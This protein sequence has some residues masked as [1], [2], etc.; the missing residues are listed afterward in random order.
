MP[1][2]ADNG[3]GAEPAHERLE[4]TSSKAVARMRL[5]LGWQSANARHTDCLIAPRLSLRRDLFPPE[6]EAQV[7]GQTVGH[8]ASHRFSPGELLAAPDDRLC[9]ELP[10]TRFDRYFLGRGLIEPRAGRFYP[11]GILAG[12]DGVSRLDRHPFRVAGV[13]DGKL[14]VDLNHPLADRELELTVTVEDIWALPGEHGG[15]CNDIAV[16]V[17]GNGPGM[18]ARWRGQPTD[19]WSDLPY[20]R[21]DAG[22]DS[23]FYAR[24][25][26]VDHLDTTALAQVRGLYGRLLPQG[27]RVLDL[28]TSWH[29]HLPDPIGAGQ[30][31]GLGM[32]RE[33]LEANPVLD[34]RL[35]HDLNRSPDLP[36]PDAAFDAVVCTVSVEYL[37][38]P[39][40]VF[41]E[42]ARALRPGGRF[43]VTFSNRWFPPKVIR[44]WEGIHELERP[45]LVSEYF[46]ESGLFENLQTWSMRGLPRP[47]EDKYA[48]R[49]PF[50]DPVYAVWAERVGS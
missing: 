4:R 22:P 44:V 23:A 48:D 38:R 50:S 9:F 21:T 3:L 31:T 8:R 17:C 11:K 10:A 33:E 35:V 43:V 45:G 27:G 13:G 6:L 32:N 20:L 29:S 15:R 7:M 19:F 46:L 5:E 30:V 37:T 24:P 41:R 26:F 28:M 39:L 47:E 42:V 14:L 25:R 18:Q 1:P 16:M 40:E 49:M 36:F 2:G 34:E 12:V